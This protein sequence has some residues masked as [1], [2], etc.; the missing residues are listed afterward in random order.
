MEVILLEKV[1][2]LGDPEIWSQLKPDMEEILIP[3]GKAVSR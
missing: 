1:A 2:K 3:T